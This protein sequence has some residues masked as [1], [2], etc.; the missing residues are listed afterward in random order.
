MEVDVVS[1][2]S[3]I[4][5]PLSSPPHSEKEE[6]NDDIIQTEKEPLEE[7]MEPEEI[8]VIQE[9]QIMPLRKNNKKNYNLDEEGEEEEDLE[10]TNSNRTKSKK[11]TNHRR[12]RAR[13]NKPKYDEEDDIDKKVPSVL[14]LLQKLRDSKILLDI[15]IPERP[16][17][18]RHLRFFDHAAIEL[19]KV[20]QNCL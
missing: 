4:P 1:D 19:R 13:R 9:K 7:K 10:T 11:R 20:E 15:H 17:D 14:D 5:I 8:I 6:A 16:F 12:N 18:E 3:P 2:D